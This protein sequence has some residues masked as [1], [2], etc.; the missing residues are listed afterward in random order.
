MFRSLQ[1]LTLAAGIPNA[2]APFV[3]NKMA[4][5]IT[6]RIGRGYST[7]LKFRFNENTSNLEVT[8]LPGSYPSWINKEKMQSLVDASIDA[9]LG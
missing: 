8:F 6:L 5:R 1:E 7:A 4:G 2:P 3:T 9:L